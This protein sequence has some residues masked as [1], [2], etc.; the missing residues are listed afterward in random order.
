MVVEW[1][2]T[3]FHS[4]H[5]DVITLD[6]WPG[7][8]AFD[9]ITNSTAML[10]ADPAIYPNPTQNHINFTGLEYATFIT[11]LNVHGQILLEAMITS[12]EEQLNVSHLAAGTYLIKTESGM[13]IK[14]AHFIKF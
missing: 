9:F 2:W 7:L 13:N 6:E 10:S 3:E 12:P 14:H 11:V 1:Y 5:D 4:F 8:L